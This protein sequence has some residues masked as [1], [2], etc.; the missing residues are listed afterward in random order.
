MQV[1]FHGRSVRGWVLEATRDVPARMLDVTKAVSPVRFF[2]ADLLGLA[3]WVSERY[4]APLATVLGRMA[5]PRVASEEGS[6]GAGAWLGA[7]GGRA[8]LAR[9]SP[10]PLRAPA[11]ASAGEPAVA[12]HLSRYSGRGWTGRFV[13]EP[14]RRFVGVRG[15]AGA[16]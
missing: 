1:P 12:D 10:T 13:E 9:P 7:G 3:R 11:A 5:P 14:A 8:P 2:D 16:R 15:P 4:V 6:L